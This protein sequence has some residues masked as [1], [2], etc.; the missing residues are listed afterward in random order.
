VSL[1]D[2]LLASACA[3]RDDDV[4]L[5]AHALLYRLHKSNGSAPLA[6][7]HL[8]Q[9]R[10]LEKARADSLRS[11]QARLA[12]RRIAQE[13]SRAAVSRRVAAAPPRDPWAATSMMATLDGGRG[14]SELAAIQDPITGLGNRRH[15]ERE[16]PRLLALSERRKSTLS[17]ALVVVDHLRTVNERFGRPVRD[18]VLKVMAELMQSHT[19]TADLIGRTGPDEFVLV[20][21]DATRDGA[22]EAC[23]RLRVAVQNHAWDAIAASLGITASVGLCEQGGKLN[24]A[25]L[26]ARADRALYFARSKG[27]NRIVLADDTM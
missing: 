21:C 6:L 1:L 4:R 18:A 20:M 17:I 25:Q 7:E 13:R 15:V 22:R 11:V 10:S 16:L 2:Q 12:Q 8:E 5:R 9:C 27:G 3:L 19:R 23:E 24:S 14:S 26:L